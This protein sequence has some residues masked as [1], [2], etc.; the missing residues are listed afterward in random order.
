MSDQRERRTNVRTLLA[1]LLSPL[2]RRGREGES[3]TRR[4]RSDH[5]HQTSRPFSPPT[6]IWGE[7]AAGTITARARQRPTAS[8]P[9][10]ERNERREAPGVTIAGRRHAPGGGTRGR[11][12]ARRAERLASGWS[13]RPARMAGCQISAYCVQTSLG[14]T[15]NRHRPCRRDLPPVRKDNMLTNDDLGCM[16]TRWLKEGLPDDLVLIPV[17][18]VKKHH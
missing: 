11:R 10:R 18:P 5:P 15:W 1:P 9:I 7:K 14:E 16:A 6:C 12:P 17:R 13:T 2:P 8:G 3:N 4:E